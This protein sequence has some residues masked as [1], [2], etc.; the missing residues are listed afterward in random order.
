MKKLL[1]STTLIAG[2]SAPALAGGM[3]EPIP[4][5]PAP[6][7]GPTSSSAGGWLVPVL[8]LLAVAAIASSGHGDDGISVSDRRLKTGLSWVG[9]H[10]GLPVWRWRYHG[11]SARYEGVMAQDV[12]ARFP[13][14]VRRAAAGGLMAVDYGRIGLRLKRVA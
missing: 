6:A 9:L 12:A 4:A 10:R 2:L 13:E 5:E 1:L 7:A 3:A 11:D 14:A 8:L